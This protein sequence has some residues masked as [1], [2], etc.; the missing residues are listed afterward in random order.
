MHDLALRPGRWYSNEHAAWASSALL[1]E[2]LVTMAGIR[3]DAHRNSFIVHDEAGRG[4]LDAL[5]FGSDVIAIDSTCRRVTRLRRLV[6]EEGYRAWRSEAAGHVRQPTFTVDSR[7]H[8]VT[9]ALIN[10]RRLVAPEV[11]LDV[12]RLILKSVSSWKKTQVNG[13][14]RVDFG[15][16]PLYVWFENNA[17][18]VPLPIREAVSSMATTQAVVAH[19]DLSPWNIIVGNEPTDYSIIDWTESELT[20][21]PWWYDIATVAFTSGCGDLLSALE[22]LEGQQDVDALDER[23]AA[24][25]ALFLSVTDPRT[26][27]EDRH[28]WALRYAYGKAD[29]A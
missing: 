5:V 7:R 26:A 27:L 12:T 23:W 17:D 16:S 15:A 3:D 20:L 4:T 29:V 18:V 9:D 8:F 28:E 6:D 19:G 10:G 24:V 21:L 11:R 22:V 14:H 25:A 2:H 13:S 1:P